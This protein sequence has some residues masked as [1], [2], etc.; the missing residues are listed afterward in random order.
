MAISKEAK[1]LAA[2]QA[3]KDAELLAALAER[4]ASGNEPTLETPPEPEEKTLTLGDQ[5]LGIAELIATA[6][7]VHRL[8]EQTLTKLWELNLQ[9]VLNER[10]LA[11]QERQQP[12]LPWDIPTQELSGDGEENTGET[13]EVHEVI[14]ADAPEE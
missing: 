2:A 12:S 13:P 1:A 6:K 8:S 4:K 3:A 9:W 5:F 7:R 10:H 14:G 11:Q